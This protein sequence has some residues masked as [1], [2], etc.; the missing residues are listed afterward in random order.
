MCS[1][2]LSGR[3]RLLDD[4]GGRGGV[5][6]GSGIPAPGAQPNSAAG[7]SAPSGA[8]LLSDRAGAYAGV[9]SL[10]DDGEHDV[11]Y[12]AQETAAPDDG[13]TPHLVA[14]DCPLEAPPDV[15]EAVRVASLQQMR[16]AIL[17]APD[18]DAV[19]PFEDRTNATL[20]RFLRAREWKVNCPRPVDGR[21]ARQNHTTFF[22]LRWSSHDCRCRWPRRFIWST[23][24][25]GPRS[26]G[27][28]TPARRAQR[29]H[30][31]GSLIV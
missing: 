25:G 18:T 24:A 30:V 28:W 6:T 7:R 17:A 26:A 9:V 21:N 12:D 19:E 27:R 22:L 31:S 20:E 11:F 5:A 10:G 1:S 15:S 4:D 8:G 16:A 13:A 14:E 2:D 3:K 23:A 29:K